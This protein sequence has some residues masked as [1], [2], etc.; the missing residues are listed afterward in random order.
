MHLHHRPPVALGAARGWASPAPDFPSHS[1]SSPN[2]RVEGLF[3]GCLEGSPGPQ[4]EQIIEIEETRPAW[5]V[6]VVVV[7]AD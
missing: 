6:V 2:T 1:L 5:W 4:D 7:V 3:E